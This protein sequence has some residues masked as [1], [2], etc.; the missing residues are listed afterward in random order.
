MA[1]FDNKLWLLS[2][3]RNSFICTDDTGLL[4]LLFNSYFL[5]WRL[6]NFILV[7]TKYIKRYKF[8]PRPVCVKKL[9][10]R[11]LLYSYHVRSAV[12]V[13]FGRPFV[14]V[15]SFDFIGSSVLFRVWCCR[16]FILVFQDS[17][18]HWKKLRCTG[19]CT[20]GM[21]LYFWL[22]GFWQLSKW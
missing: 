1:F 7:L 16:R 14:M 11:I 22:G 3:I 10:E 12:H 5:I 9:T 15:V 13:Y 2:H 6:C 17:K 19:T 18:N 8:D 4:L 21:K 20:S